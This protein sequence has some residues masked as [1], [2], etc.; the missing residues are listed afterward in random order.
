MEKTESSLS[1]GKF[2]GPITT[3]LSL[4]EIKI[5]YKDWAKA[6]FRPGEIDFSIKKNRDSFSVE[7]S[8]GRSVILDTIS[9][10]L[11]YQWDAAKSLV[12]EGC[13]EPIL[14]S[15]LAMESQRVRYLENVLASGTNSD[16]NASMN[17]S[18]I[19]RIKRFMKK[20]LAEGD[21]SFFKIARG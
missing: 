6:Y 3:I 19:D 17:D 9:A 5:E 15:G 4:R 12:I 14:Y 8:V 1:Q 16:S 21:Y 10:N 2:T 20:P 7:V 13:L 11:W 18:D